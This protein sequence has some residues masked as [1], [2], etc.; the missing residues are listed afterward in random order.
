MACI[1]INRLSEL[2]SASDVSINESQLSAFG[3]YA[4][5]LVEWNEKINLTAITDPKGIEEKHFLDSCLP[6]NLFDIPSN[7]AVIDVGTGAGFPGIPFKIMRPDISLTLLDSLQKRIGFL[8]AVLDAVS[9]SAEAVHGRAEDMGKLSNMRE[10]YDIATAR[11]VARLSVLSEYCLPFVKVEGYF[12]A[13]KGG[14]CSDEIDASLN[15]IGTLGGKLE[16]AVEYQLPSGD[17]RTLVVIKKI[18]PTLAAY[19]RPKGKMNKKP[20]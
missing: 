7:A 13:L 16:K 4:D 18:K 20:L 19:P 12:I 9:L 14:D 8:N 3:R 11:A 15:A 5:L 6:L 17:R 1:D 10:Q 2:F